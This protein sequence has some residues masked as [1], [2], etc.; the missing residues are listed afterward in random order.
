MFRGYYRIKFLTFISWKYDQ[1]L[2]NVN[3][4][5]LYTNRGIGVTNVP[6]RVNCAPEITQITLV[7]A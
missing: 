3:G 6:L 7:A 4:M 5:W 1:G 2:Y